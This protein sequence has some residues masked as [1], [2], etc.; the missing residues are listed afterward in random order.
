MMRAA[1][2]L[3]PWPTPSPDA[4][5]VHLL[6]GK[7]FWHQTAFCVH[8]LRLHGGA[9]RPV[10]VDDGSFDSALAAEALRL[11]PGATVLS[12]SEIES[13]LDRALPEHRFPTLRTQ[14]RTYI[15][16]RKLTDVHAGEHG[17]QVVLD[18]DMLFF[19]KPG[20]LLD[21]MRSPS[22]SLLMTDV[23]NAYGYS[24]DT[25]TTLAGRDIP[26]CVNVGVCGFRSDA[27]DWDKLEYYTAS[28]L[29]RHG[30]SYYLEQALVAL[31]LA[32]GGFIRLPREDYRVMPEI[33]ECM[34]PTAV[35]HHYVDLSKRGYFRHA[36]QNV[37]APTG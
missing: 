36:W 10:F 30:S 14:R 20:A 12:A 23:K 34:H 37:L 33:E 1:A 6:T 18:S 22:G 16:L 32:D 7:R 29:S 2:L 17:W 9:I 15:H 11:F 35:L 3:P 13:R 5:S 28:L 19:R 4:P 24:L 27:L 25:L 26:S 8:S 31:L 21:W